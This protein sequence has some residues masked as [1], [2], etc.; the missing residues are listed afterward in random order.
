LKATA[1]PDI[2]A[3]YEFNGDDGYINDGSYVCKGT[4]I[5][6][7][8]S[9]DKGYEIDYW[10]INGEKSH[11]IPV[12]NS[13]DQ[14][15]T[16]EN[17]INNITIRVECKEIPEYDIYYSVFDTNGPEED[18][19]LNGSVSINVERKGMRSYKGSKEAASEGSITAYRDSTVTLN[20]RADEGY[21]VQYWKVDGSIVRENGINIKS[22]SYT[23][24]NLEDDHT[25]SVQFEKIGTDSTYGY[26]GDTGSGTITGT[27]EGLPVDESFILLEDATVVLTASPSSGYKI[28]KW[29]ENGNDVAESTDTYSYTSIDGLGVDIRVHFVQV[30]YEIKFGADKYGSVTA[31]VNGSSTGAS[32]SQIRGGTEITFT[33]AP[34]QGYTLDR[35]EV[36]GVIAAGET[37]N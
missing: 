1:I 20:A 10:L 11:G 19:G 3:Y 27:V 22:S 13:D 15:F 12:E 37:E 29:T 31:A 8:A 30:D 16:I 7:T 6:F 28:D 26:I 36:D 14:T 4:D 17:I 9:P 32:P 25:V 2:E 35:W 34:N 33:A 5:T 24:S 23:F 18:G 21:R